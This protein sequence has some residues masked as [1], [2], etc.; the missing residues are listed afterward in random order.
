MT[1]HAITR[2][3]S[4]RIAE[5]ELTHLGRQSIDA[6]RAA[7]EHEAY[8]AALTDL[9]CTLERLP[10]ADDL[11]DAVFVEDTA[12]VLPEVAI[13]T[14][15]GAPSRQPETPSVTQ[16][17]RRYRTC[18]SIDAPGTLDGGDV[19]QL[20]DRLYTGRTSRSNDAGIEQLAAILAPFGY[21]VRGVEVS[22]CLHLKSAVSWLGGDTV[23]L[24]PDWIEDDLFAGMNRIHVDPAEPHAANVLAIG[25]TLLCPATHGRTHERLRAAG[26]TVIPVDIT[27]LAKAEAGMTCSSLILDTEA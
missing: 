1:L 26:F 24:N 2:A 4:P 15:P 8:E 3:P 5:C 19:L 21:T 13:I 23:L 18:C 27:E 17:L 10:A 16:A 25:A 12:V 7:A 22:G 9:G 11:P 6:N 20:G 14:R